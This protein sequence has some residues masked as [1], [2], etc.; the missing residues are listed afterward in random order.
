MTTSKFANKTM[1]KIVMTVIDFSFV[2]GIFVMAV[3]FRNKFLQ[4]MKRV[5]GLQ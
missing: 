5:K 2:Y 1:I 3:F 4:V